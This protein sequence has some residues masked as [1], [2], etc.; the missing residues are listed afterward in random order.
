MPHTPSK[1]QPTCSQFIDVTV[2]DEGVIRQVFFYGG[3]DGNRR[4]IC[5]SII[6]QNR[7]ISPQTKQQ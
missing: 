4:R 1:P 6:H 7:S 3:C 2:D 5:T